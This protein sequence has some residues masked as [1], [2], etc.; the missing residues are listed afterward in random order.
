MDVKGLIERLRAQTVISETPFARVVQRRN[1]DG[2]EAAATLETLEADNRR[3]REALGKIANGAP[4]SFDRGQ[5]Y[6]AGFDNGHY[7]A[8]SIA[9]AALGEGAASD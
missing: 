5:S 2:P 9:R 4:S 8:A 1:P 7:W 6:L 3:L